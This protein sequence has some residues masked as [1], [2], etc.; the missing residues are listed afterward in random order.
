[1]NTRLVQRRK[2][3][4]FIFAS[5]NCSLQCWPCWFEC[6]GK[7]ADTQAE[8]SC[9]DV[10][11]RVGRMRRVCPSQLI[12]PQSTA[13]A[14]VARLQGGL[15]AEQSC[16]V[17][18]ILSRGGEWIWREHT[19]ERILLPCQALQMW[20]GS[21]WCRAQV[22]SPWRGGVWR[23]ILSG[24]LIGTEVNGEQGWLPLC[25]HFLREWSGQG[26][27]GDIQAQ[28]L[29]SLFE[30]HCALTRLTAWNEVN[31]VKGMRLEDFIRAETGEAVCGGR[32]PLPGWSDFKQLVPVV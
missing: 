19:V 13:P 11:R 32:Y 27:F 30:A 24:C 16:H 12:S 28:Y 21:V 17:G 31:P 7:E 8:Q 22:L 6:V 23:Q 29:C 1:M 2:N 10:D 26:N 5:W 14:V 3:C 4:L 18:V 9:R 15:Q 20:S 25:S